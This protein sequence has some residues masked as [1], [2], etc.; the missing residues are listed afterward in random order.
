M[1]VSFLGIGMMILMDR[2]KGW[3]WRGGVWS[4]GLVSGL[5]I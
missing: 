2:D 5:S 1:T 3:G 4:R